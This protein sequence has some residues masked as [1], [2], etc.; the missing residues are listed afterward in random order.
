[1]DT[2]RGLSKEQVQIILDGVPSLHDLFDID[3]LDTLF[4]T[5]VSDER[6]KTKNKNKKH[7]AFFNQIFSH[8]F[9][10]FFFSF[11]LFL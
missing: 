8:F 6:T 4:E 10:F 5:I 2:E 1:M 7:V 9:F 3:D 11:F